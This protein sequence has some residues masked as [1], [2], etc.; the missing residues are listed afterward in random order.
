MSNLIK[1]GGANVS[2]LEI[3]LCLRSYPGLKLAAAVGV[4]H[5]TLGEVI[6]LCAA[7]SAGATLDPEAIRSHLRKELS[8][9][10]L[11]KHVLLFREDELQYTGNQKLQVGPLR[12]AALE[13][14]AIEKIEIEG[15][16]YGENG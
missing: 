14:L 11:P 4:P 12:E 15:F 8:A 3:E 10:K 13:R 6:V 9:F 1:T 7:V 5:P 2:P 16:R